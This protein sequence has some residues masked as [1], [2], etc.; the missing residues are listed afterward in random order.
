MGIAESSVG[1][2]AD[3]CLP[4]IALLILLQ[5]KGQPLKTEPAGIKA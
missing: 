5:I 2:L 3:L 4:V 1:I